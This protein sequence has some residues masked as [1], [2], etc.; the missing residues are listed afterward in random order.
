M[1]LLFH[2]IRIKLRIKLMKF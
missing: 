2:F 1:K